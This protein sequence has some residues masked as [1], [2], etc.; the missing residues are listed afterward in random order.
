M[1]N[2]LDEKGQAEIIGVIL[3]I[4]IIV[5]AFS[6]IQSGMVPQW[7]QEVEFNHYQEVNDDIQK[8]HNVIE[9][10]AAQGHSE[11]AEI[12]LGTT[13]PERGPL[14]NPPPAQGTLETYETQITI[15]N[16]TAKQTDAQCKWDGSTINY[17]NQA[18][19]YTPNYNYQEGTPPIHIE[20]NTLI[21][22]YPENP[23]I[24]KQNLI[25]GDK[26]NQILL[27]GQHEKT[28]YTLETLGIY[29]KS[30]PPNTVAMES[31]EEQKIQLT[32]ET[33]L[34]QAWQ[35]LQQKDKIETIETNENTVKITLEPGTYYF[36]TT[37]LTLDEDATPEPEYIM[38]YDHDRNHTPP[39]TIEV[40][41]RDQ[42]NN[43]LPGQQVNFSYELQEDNLNEGDVT[44][45]NEETETDERGIAKTL[46][47]VNYE[48]NIDEVIHIISELSPFIG[49]CSWTHNNI[50]IGD[51][52]IEEPE[53]PV[54]WNIIINEVDID[55]RDN[56]VLE[57]EHTRDEP[58]DTETEVTIT[59]Y[60]DHQSWTQDSYSTTLT[61]SDFDLDEEWEKGDPIQRTF[62]NDDDFDG[63]F[64]TNH[65]DEV[66]VYI[67][68]VST[69]FSV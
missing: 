54:D 28:G 32:L 56:F 50:I 6:L 35:Q 23:E 40:E 12:Q 15:N 34:P 26:I 59:V 60:G 21:T 25:T 64:H 19:K 51:P 9:R 55:P 38:T 47:T 69:T 62:N 53:P 44:I 36:K 41:V 52:D 57:L 65:I 8:L 17:T 67:E 30:A 61:F 1:K 2:Q 37:A 22:A 4:S 43:P 24:Q 3:I 20:H 46:V 58:F 31:K 29:P 14:I 27:K 42:Y 68:G 13:Y 39:T 63:D 48:G 18:I 16:A 7:N 5:I 11:S 10:V 49:N 45:Y 33:Q 66:E